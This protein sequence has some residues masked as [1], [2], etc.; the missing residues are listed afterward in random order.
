MDISGEHQNGS[1]L[2]YAILPAAPAHPLCAHRRRPPRPVQ[3][4]HQRRRQVYRGGDQG[5]GADGR[6]R[7]GC[8]AEGRGILCVAAFRFPSCTVG[9]LRLRDGVLIE[10]ELTDIVFSK[11]GGTCYGGTPPTDGPNPGCCN[12]CDDVRE[13]YVR[14]G[15]SFVN[16]DSVEQVRPFLACHPRSSPLRR[17]RLTL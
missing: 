8:E 1:S 11:L 16:P 6:R 3:D 2:S 15:W 12:S 7:A 5:K 4:A 9:P 17:R 14:R 13:A 10:V